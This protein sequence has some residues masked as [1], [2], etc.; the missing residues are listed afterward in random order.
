[1]DIFSIIGFIFG[2]VLS[3]SIYGLFIALIV[4]VIRYLWNK[5]SNA[6]HQQ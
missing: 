2:I 3:L 1:M 4:S 6:K 5:G